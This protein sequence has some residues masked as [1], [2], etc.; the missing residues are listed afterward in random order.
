MKA[1]LRNVAFLVV[2]GVLVPF[3]LLE[4]AFR[5]LPV[6]N[7]PFLEPVSASDPIP[8]FPPHRDYTYSAGWDFS[9]RA[10]KH[11][12]NLGFNHVADYRA[13]EKTPLM[14]VVGDSFVEAHEVDA[15]KSAA[16][17]LH[18]GLGGQ[19]RVYSLGISG[20]PL[21]QYL[22]FAEF[23]RDKFRPDALTVVV[24]RNDFDESL[25]KYKSEPRLHYFTDSGELV[26][27]DYRISPAK[28]LLRSSAFLRYATHHLLVAHRLERWK[29]RL[30][31]VEE[32]DPQ[33][34]ARKRLPD[35][36]RA[37]DF[38]LE[39]LPARS[40]LPPE[41]ILLVLDADRP[42]MYEQDAAQRAARFHGQMMRY[43]A[44]Q[45]RARGFGIV[46]LEP[47]FVARHR[48]DGSRFEFRLDSHWNE[49]GHQVVAA[50]I[51]DSALFTR[52]FGAR[53][54]VAAAGRGVQHAAS[55][56]Q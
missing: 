1:L 38:F 46:D 51:R 37:V 52:T 15:G 26:R 12:N 4:G 22:A 28:K 17:L 19:G 48:R 14:M 49:L 6:A 30:T 3:L 29:R 33:V 5:L 53:A 13:D 56:V 27:I 44:E 43:V 21:S 20:A 41:R 35:A 7:P 54:S 47:V 50:E 8:H 18:A 11:S 42:A 55:S 24:I 25:L 45:A 32:M 23:A 2:F 31:G 39:Q 9:I 34:E 40:G 36:K 16:E 10:R